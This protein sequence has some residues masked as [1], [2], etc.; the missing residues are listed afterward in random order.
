MKRCVCEGWIDAKGE[1]NTSLPGKIDYREMIL[2]FILDKRMRMK[3]KKKA[4]EVRAKKKVKDIIDVVI[5]GVAV[6]PVVV[7]HQ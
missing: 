3:K 1:N 2:T 5:G 7:L 6:N 4:R